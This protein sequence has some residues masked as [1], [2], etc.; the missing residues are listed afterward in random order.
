[1]I[2]LFNLPKLDQNNCHFKTLDPNNAAYVDAFFTYL[3]SQLY[4]RLNFI[5]GLDFY[6]S[7]LGIKNNY[8]INISDDLDINYLLVV[9]FEAVEIFLHL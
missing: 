8:H 9:F 7:Y 5:H 2:N 1:M 4:N 3:I 6:G